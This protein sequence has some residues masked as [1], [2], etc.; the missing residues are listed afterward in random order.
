MR[1]IKSLFITAL[2]ISAVTA[3]AQTF[4]PDDENCMMCHKY[5]G[6]SRVSDEGELRVFYVNSE[7]YDHSVHTRVK[8]SGCHTDIKEIPHKEAEPVNCTTECHITEAGSA[9]P[10]SHKQAEK[11]LM[12]SIHNPENPNVRAKIVEDFP[13]C[14]D[15]H[16]NPVFRFNPDEVYEISDSRDPSEI[17]NKCETCH[18]DN[19][20]YKYFFNHVSHRMK[21]LKHDESSIATCSECHSKQEMAEKHKL[22]NAAGT[23]LDTFHGKA[24][25]FGFENAPTCIDCHVKTGDSVHR[26]MSQKNPESAIF[27]G[28]RYKTCQDPRCHPTAK[29]GFGEIRMHVAIDKDL[30]PIEFY[31]ALAFTVLT[32]GVFFPLVGLLILELI[33]EIFPNFSLRRK[34]KQKGDSK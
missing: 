9:K 33:R 16:N 25:G 11:A 18:E 24:I 29:K 28:E 5:P 3:G 1:F 8:C 4:T 30:Y 20:D 7:R 13:D 17:Y 27:E 34:G 15:C 6:L 22:K 26:I 14:K 31:V 2:L 21:N 32:L 19:I 10:F 12:E 23:Y